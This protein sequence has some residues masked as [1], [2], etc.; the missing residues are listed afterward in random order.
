MAFFLSAPGQRPSAP[1][2]PGMRPSAPSMTLENRLSRPTRLNCWKIMPRR[3]RALRTDP[4]TRPSFCTVSPNTAIVPPASIGCRPVI[5]RSRVDLPDPD[6][7][8]RATIS[9]GATSRDTPSSAFRAPKVLDTFRTDATAAD[10]VMDTLGR[11][12]GARRMART[13]P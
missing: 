9:P 2:Q 4:V 3:A 6:G 13:G 11:C 12:S 7:P 5:E 8:I 1:C 10:V